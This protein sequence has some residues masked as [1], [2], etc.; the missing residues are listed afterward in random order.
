[1]PEVVVAIVGLEDGHGGFRS[2]MLFGSGSRSAEQCVLS[3]VRQGSEQSIESKKR[4]DDQIVRVYA[5]VTTIYALA[6]MY[7]SEPLLKPPDLPMERAQFPTI[8]RASRF[9]VH[10]MKCIA[11]EVLR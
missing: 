11:T 2:M 7:A 3:D 5:S 9:G 6:C 4:I 1:V 10:S 8:A